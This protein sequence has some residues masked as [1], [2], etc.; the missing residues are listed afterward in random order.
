M[1][2]NIRNRIPGILITVLLALALALFMAILV[3]TQLLPTKFLLLAGGIFLLFA[4]CVFLLTMNARRTGSLIVG[5][6]MT[7]VLLVVL[8]AG[9][10]YLMK[11]VN[12]LDSITNVE[13]EVADVGVFVAQDSAAA[14][15]ADLTGGSIGIMD[16]L[17]QENT[18]K[19]LETIQGQIGT[20]QV[21]EY[22]GLGELVDGV[23][24]GEIDAAVFNTAYLGL[25]LDM[26]GYA[27]AAA[28]LREIYT[29]Q[30]ESV[31]Q[32]VVEN[33]N[34]GDNWNIL[35][36]FNNEEPAQGGEQVKQDRVFTMYISG[37][38]S[39]SG[40]IAKSRSDVNIIA[41][42]NVD[43]RQV[44][45]VSTP[46][47]FYVPL[48]ISNG[49]PDKLTHA[50][51]YG[52]DVSIGTL[53]MLYDTEIDYYFRVNFSGFEKIIDALGGI[54]VESPKAFTAV[55]GEYSFKKGENKLDGAKALA[56]ARERYAFADGD[57]QRGKNQMAVIKAVINK[58][59]SPAILTGYTGIMES[60]S[61]SFETSMP[62]DKIAELVRDQLDKGGSW[63]IVS[64]SV[65]GTGDSK[66]PY[67][68]STKAYVMIPD[69][70][71]VNTA[72]S[73]MNQVKNGEILE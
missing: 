17:D 54:T 52:I 18:D 70:E 32:S 31:I 27:D 64:Y 40:L 41:T 10:P 4:V 5:C 46:R 9:T 59:M 35:D 44:L 38:D 7:V 61:G 39:R 25:L 37:I 20:V 66:K 1:K 11:A 69:Q 45:L 53:E 42:V 48:P 67:S 57:R 16:V 55:G 51:I 15:L 29:F 13:V 68:L 33:Q 2:K 72:I 71:T 28:Q 50:G 30:A 73:K 65:D 19:A 60:V 47:D 49:K 12:T 36:I 22:A 14:E 3:K 8:M 26:E 43:T 21:Q 23:L 24:Q 63:N 34:K 62:Y 6:I 58:A 56:F